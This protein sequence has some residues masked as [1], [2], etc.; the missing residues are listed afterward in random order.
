MR[1][2]LILFFISIAAGL[3]AQTPQG[4]GCKPNYDSTQAIETILAKY[5]TARV[6]VATFDK[7]K[8]EW[9]VS[10]ITSA[11]TKKDEC[12][13]RNG[14]MIVTYYTATLNAINGKVEVEKT[15]RKVVPN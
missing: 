3:R 8:C 5:D 4:A 7:A 14:C 12:P 9:A 2:F 11:Y 1:I 6:P 10:F 15:G 13:H